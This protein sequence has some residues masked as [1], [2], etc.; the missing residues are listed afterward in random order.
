MPARDLFHAA[1]R[2]ALEKE[3]WVIT[4]DPLVLRVGGVELSVDL[5]A[6]RF[7]AAE[8]EGRRIAVEI[9]S[10][11]GTSAI[12]EFHTALGQFL[13]YEEALKDQAPP[14]VLFLAVPVDTYRT[15]FA[16]QFIQTVLHRYQV[17][18]MV[19]DPKLEVIVEW[20]T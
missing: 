12:S 7:L 20:H 9:K 19:Y 6:E 15:F 5:G 3:G 8:K 18:I 11:A 14:R 10:F 2:L 4:H 13:N 17:R 16:L 1:V